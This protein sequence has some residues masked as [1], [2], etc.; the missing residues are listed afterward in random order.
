MRVSWLALETTGSDG[1]FD[2]LEKAALEEMF[3][4]DFVD[5]CNIMHVTMGGLSEGPL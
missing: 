5:T 4:S 1:T 3:E 2:T